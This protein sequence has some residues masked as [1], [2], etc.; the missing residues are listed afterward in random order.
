M[1]HYWPKIYIE[2]GYSNVDIV[3]IAE[4]NNLIGIMEPYNSREATIPESRHR[5]GIGEANYGQAEKPGSHQ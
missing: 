5:T 1:M 2:K 4:L 3:S